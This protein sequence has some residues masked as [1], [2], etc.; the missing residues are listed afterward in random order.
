M[1]GV[2]FTLALGFALAFAESGLGLGIVMPG[3]TAVVVLAASMRSTTDILLLGVAVMI[4]ASMGDHVGY[5]L[6][7]RYGDQLRDTKPVR[8]LGVRHF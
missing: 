8:R 6:G 4:G 1:S 5:L 7:R 3:E 2:V